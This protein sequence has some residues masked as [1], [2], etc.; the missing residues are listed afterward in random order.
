M[1]R[2]LAPDHAADRLA[3]SQCGVISR[4]QARAAKLTS[5]QIRTRVASGRWRQVLPG[6]YAVAGAPTSWEQDAM[7]AVLAGPDGTV[8]SHLTAA[9]L[10]GLCDPPPLPHVTVPPKASGR[11]RNAMVHRPVA[12]LDPADHGV[13]GSFPCTTP[14]RTLVDCAALLG[15]D[16]FCEMVDAALCRGLASAGAVRAAAGRV[17][18]AP[19]RKGLPRVER[20]LEVWAPG[21]APGSPAEMR[22]ARLIVSWGLPCPERQVEIRDARGGFVARCDLGWRDLKVVLEYD[23]AE[24]HG[25]RRAPLDAARQQRIE[26]LGWRVIRVRKV[27]VRPPARA[28][29]AELLALF[30]DPR[31]A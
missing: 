11:F 7:V 19:G 8:L 3:A 15:D 20:A 30:A 4:R 10:V 27:D 13:V 5:K 18:R 21:P 31:A 29:R 26:A 1:Q 25:P 9:A 22:L 16:V 17:A 12:A 28:L 2:D 24:W 14:A 6:V 23:G